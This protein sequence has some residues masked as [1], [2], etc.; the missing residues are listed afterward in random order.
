MQRVNQGPTDGAG[1]A[2]GTRAEA[3]E[4]ATDE[5]QAEAR[6]PEEVEAQ[7][8]AVKPEEVETTAKTKAQVLEYH[9]VKQRI[10]SRRSRKKDGILHRKQLEL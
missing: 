9:I 7:A 10:T 3:T 5:A 4:R 8:A 6:A 2:A 1:E